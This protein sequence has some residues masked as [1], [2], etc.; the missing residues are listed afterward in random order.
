MKSKILSLLLLLAIV[1]GSCTKEGTGGNSSIHGVIMRNGVYVIPNTVVYIKY[2]TTE[3]PGDD[4]QYYDDSFATDSDGV[5]EFKGLKKGD[6]FLFANGF[7]ITGGFAVTG[8]M[9]VNLGRKQNKEL[10]PFIVNN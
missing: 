9:V 1:A 5:F 4:P 8:Q 10:D 7:D 6:Y 2:G 3:F